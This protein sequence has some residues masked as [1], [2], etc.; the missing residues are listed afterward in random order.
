MWESISAS[1]GVSVRE[2]ISVSNGVS[3]RES[4]SAS[5]CVPVRVL[6]YALMDY[7]L[8]WYKCCPH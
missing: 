4:I 5:I 7:H 8:T 2:S 6:T 3:M 1:N